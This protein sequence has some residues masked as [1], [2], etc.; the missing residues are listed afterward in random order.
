MTG[1]VV[2]GGV[3]LE[4]AVEGE[5]I[6]RGRQRERSTVKPRGEAR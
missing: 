1:S 6:A 3:S 4:T 2:A 5:I